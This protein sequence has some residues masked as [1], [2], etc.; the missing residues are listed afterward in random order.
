M[1][2][3]LRVLRLAQQ[4]EGR[5]EHETLIGLVDLDE[6]GLLR[7]RLNAGKIAQHARL[8]LPSRALGKGFPTL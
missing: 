4:P 3:V 8:L 2:G 6:L 7:L 1:N 5:V